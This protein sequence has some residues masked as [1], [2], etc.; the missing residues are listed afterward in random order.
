[1]KRLFPFTLIILC[2]SV[3][4]FAADSA[5]ISGRVLDPSGNPIAHA[6]IHL[7]Q[8][9]GAAS[10]STATTSDGA[11]S[12]V[13]IAPGDYLLGASA[14]SLSL[15]QPVAVRLKDGETKQLDLDLVLSVQHSQM[16]VTSAAAPQSLDQTSKALYVVNTADAERRGL[17]TVSDSLRLV[18]GLRITTR[19]GPG[20]FTTIQT[21]G[22]RATDTAIL[23]DG[24]RLRDP[25]AVQGDASSFISD[26][27]LVDSARIEVLQGSGSSLYGTN[28]IGGTINIISGQGGSPLHGDVD[29]QGGGLGLF[30]GLARVGGSALH[31]RLTYSGGV[32][33]LNETQGVEGG[34]PARNWSAQGRLNYAVTPAFRIGARLMADTDYLQYQAI[35]YPVNSPASTFIQALP[36]P[37][38]QLQLANRGLPFDTAGATFVPALNDADARRNGHFTTALFHLDD[39]LTPRLSWRLYYQSAGTHR[40]NLDGPLGPIGAYEPSFHTSDLYDGHI[41]TVQARADYIAAPWQVITAGYEFEREHYENF[42]TDANPNPANRVYSLVNVGQRSNA[43]FAQ[44][45]MQVLSG[46]LLILLSGRFQNFQLNSPFFLGGISPYSGIPLSSPPDSYTG[47]ASVAYFIHRTST[48]LRS[49]VGNGYRVPSL[50]ERFGTYFFGGAFTA[51]GDPRLSPERAISADAG[52]DQYLWGQRL[53]L[54]GSFFYTRLQ[55]VISFDTLGLIT[56]ATDPY[57]RYGGYFNTGGGIAHGVEVSGEFRPSRSTAIDASYTYTNALD[58]SSQ[59][60]TGTG[61]N[62]IQTPRILPHAVTLRAAQKFGKRVEAALDFVGGSDFLYPLYGLAYRFDGPRQLG[63]STSYTVPLTDRLNMRLYA[64]V[65]NTLDQQ[66]YDDGYLTPQRWAVGGVRFSF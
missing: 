51:Y 42:S 54:S 25:T 49:H 22:L 60:T 33:H 31:N 34:T 2:A 52:L 7:D 8:A 1:V 44:D 28:S 11:Y 43:A 41:D 40:D 6:E 27:L 47:D 12:F 58:R 61:S 15:K 36:L 65:S 10:L 64:R 53:R 21:R 18:P 38:T 45:Q 16:T 3:A 39:Q 29:L 19:G 62:P 35:P 4:S 30:R 32:A 13:G 9:T 55:Q 24:F 5:A 17:F 57:G 37:S 48:K 46:R 26:L 20:A 63:L 59:F 23:V 14:P 56:P 66:Y 50:Y